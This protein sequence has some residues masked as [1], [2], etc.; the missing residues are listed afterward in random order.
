MSSKYL[1]TPIP[2]LFIRAVAPKS[3]E[4]APGRAGRLG[5]ETGQCDSS[6]RSHAVRQRTCGSGCSAEFDGIDQ[7]V[8]AASSYLGC[9]YGRP[10]D[11]GRFQLRSPASSSRSTRRQRCSRAGRRRATPTSRPSRSRQ[12]PLCQLP[13][14]D[15]CR[16]RDRRGRDPSPKFCRLSGRGR[17]CPRAPERW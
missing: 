13:E 9:R 10:L 5:C 2:R 1:C 7:S 15:S 8:Q 6:C 4:C 12:W 11:N 17:D 16:R 14:Q 3:R